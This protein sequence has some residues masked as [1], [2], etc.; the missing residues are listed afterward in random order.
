MYIPQVAKKKVRLDVSLSSEPL[1]FLDIATRTSEMGSSNVLACDVLFQ[2]EWL[3][4]K[5]GKRAAGVN[6]LLSD[7]SVDFRNNPD[8]FDYSLWL[9][10]AGRPAYI[11]GD[12]VRFRKII[13]LLE[14][15]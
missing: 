10:N 6:A 7:G 13:R 4:H 3:P 15:D 8:A 5:K 1:Y 9:N 12:A 2:L 11:S 14:K